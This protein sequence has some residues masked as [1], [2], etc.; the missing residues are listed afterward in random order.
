MEGG[1]NSSRECVVKG[2]QR[3]QGGLKDKN[4]ERENMLLDVLNAGGHMAGGGGSG[5]DVRAK[6][7]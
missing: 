4:Q 5:E 3:I 6:A 7:A 2:G 1:G